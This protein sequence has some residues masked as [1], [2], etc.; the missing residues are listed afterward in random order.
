V[1]AFVI[2]T[3]CHGLIYLWKES[4]SVAWRFKQGR[5][6]SLR[7]S[8]VQGPHSNDQSQALL[9]Q[10]ARDQNVNFLSNSR[11]TRDDAEPAV[12]AWSTMVRNEHRTWS[13]HQ[14]WRFRSTFKDDAVWWKS[15]RINKKTT[16]NRMRRSD[17]PTDDPPTGEFGKKCLA[18]DRS[19][20]SM[21]RTSDQ[22]DAKWTAGFPRRGALY[23]IRLDTRRAQ[24]T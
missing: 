16:G 13:R 19:P 5:R 23:G 8:G 22:K 14:K 20:A 4:D 17:A 18:H 3:F 24:Q 11:Q 1:P 7:A 10:P 6:V 2:H 21:A 15:S 12:S 9:K